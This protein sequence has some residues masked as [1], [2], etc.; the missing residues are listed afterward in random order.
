MK[1]GKSKAVIISPVNDEDVKILT[2]KRYFF[3]WRNEKANAHLYKLCI[4]G[5]DDIL[6]VMA[7]VDV[8]AEYRMEIK[9]LAS[10][11]ENVGD[12]KDYE[13]IAGCLIGFAC[14][15]SVKRYGNLACV[16][17]KPKTELQEHYRRKYGMID[18][19]HQLCVEGLSLIKLIN[20]YLI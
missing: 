5:E 11:R 13:G 9:L 12:G 1:T 10:A 16:S 3:S 18:A 2:K 14:R 6:G 15:E 20:K 7:L 19:G 4:A 8:P 17:L